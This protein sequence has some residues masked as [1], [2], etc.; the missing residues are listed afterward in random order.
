MKLITFKGTGIRGYINHEIHFNESVT[1]LVGINGSGKTTVLKLISG[2]TTPS[3]KTLE[4]IDYS[5]IELTLEHDTRTYIISST[6]NKDSLTIKFY[7]I[8]KNIISE[9][10][11]HRNN[12]ESRIQL[13]SEDLLNNE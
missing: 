13:D 1:F 8:E 11:I 4:S 7:H 12:S 6:K 2:L 10:S 3:Y 5:N 9:D